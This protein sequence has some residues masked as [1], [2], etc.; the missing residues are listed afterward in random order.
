MGGGSELVENRFQV[1]VAEVF[2]VTLRDAART[3]STL[4]L[5]GP[6]VKAFR[7]A[8]AHERDARQHYLPLCC[9]LWLVPRRLPKVA[10]S[11]PAAA[12]AL[13][14]AGTIWGIIRGVRDP[15]PSQ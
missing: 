4:C 12:L 13:F 7:Q 3:R 11:G 5:S 2:F 6:T 10:L 9:T 14:R 1:T 15:L 8:T